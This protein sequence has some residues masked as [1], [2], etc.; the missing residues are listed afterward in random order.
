MTP[1]I[2]LD[3]IVNKGFLFKIEGQECAAFF[4]FLIPV[5]SRVKYKK[6]CFR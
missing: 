5:E 6:L 2:I 4:F 1:L 3:I